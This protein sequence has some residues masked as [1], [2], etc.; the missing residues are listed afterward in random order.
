VLTLPQSRPLVGSLAGVQ[1]EQRTAQAKRWDFPTVVAQYKATCDWSKPNV[2]SLSTGKPVQ[3]SHALPNCAAELANDG[4]NDDCD[5]YWATDVQQQPGDAWWQVDLEK[6]TTIG[7]VVVV[8]YYGDVR[9]YGFTI[10][11]SLDGMAWEMVADWREN[12]QPATANGYTCL[13]EPRPARYVR[14]TQML[15]SANTGRHLVEVM[16]YER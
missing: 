5:S 10:E 13:F 14:V 3:C 12:R 8:S 1:V 15:N 7:R 2:V 6:P 16:V 9:H 11:T 4:R